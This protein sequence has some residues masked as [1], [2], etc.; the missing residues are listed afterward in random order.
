MA[1]KKQKKESN[2]GSQFNLPYGSI[3]EDNQ[4]TY[5]VNEI[6]SNEDT[7]DETKR[8]L[9]QFICNDLT[10]K[11]IPIQ[12]YVLN[13]EEDSFVE[14]ENYTVG[15]LL[16]LLIIIIPL[17]KNGIEVTEDWIIDVTDL[18][19]LA[20]YFDEMI[21]CFKENDING[22]SEILDA[23]SELSYVMSKILKSY[24]GTLNLYELTK[25]ARNNKRINEI[26]HFKFADLGKSIEFEEGNRIM[27]NLLD[28]FCNILMEEETCYSDLLKSNSG[29]NPRQMRDTFLIIGF[30]PNSEGVIIPNPVD[31]S[32]IR[33]QNVYEFFIDCCGARKALC[34]NYKNTKDS[35]YLTRKLS[36][37]A[38]DNFIKDVDDCG[39]VHTIDI[40]VTDKTYLKKLNR[41]NIVLEDGTIHT[42][43]SEYD[44]D[45]IGT[46]VSLRSPITCAC[47]NG[48]CK[49]CYGE[50]WKY[51]FDV[52]VGI[53]AVLLLTAILTQ[54]MLSSKHLLQANAS[55]LNWSDTFL[56]FFTVD[57]EK[58][59]TSSNEKFKILIN[60]EDVIE[61]EEDYSDIQY[62]DRFKI[63]F[64]K[65]VY[66]INDLPLLLCLNMDTLDDLDSYKK[67][68]M[69]VIDA[70]KIEDDEAIFT[71]AMENNELNASLKKISQLIETNKLI[72]DFTIDESYQY[73]ADAIVEGNVNVDFIHIEFILKEMC[74]IEGDNRRL[75]RQ[76]E[77]PIIDVLRISDALMHN[78]SLSKSIVFEQLYKQITSFLD[79]YNRTESSVLDVLVN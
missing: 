50:L 11:D 51:N 69:Y 1:T 64:E 16:T 44:T 6:T 61:D 70:N 31:T 48:V 56:K 17:V 53:I 73:F 43:N 42:I 9:L 63:E 27:D 75:F 5:F 13:N 23:V 4:I 34:S 21:V 37:L 38:C 49:T 60:P 68:G 36:L 45:L 66:E 57:K 19:N 10:N 77:D 71:Y 32:Y 79:T 14:V 39:S 54:R 2:E 35:G 65:K 74:K 67:E 40:F 47:K 78:P 76:A 12:L 46:T 72:K 52:N 28:E 15:N 24:G 55:K 26:L 22:N 18:N 3:L 7:Y 33:G 25:L 8:Q 30:K 20:K 58:I 62:V 29:M 41:R 59:Y